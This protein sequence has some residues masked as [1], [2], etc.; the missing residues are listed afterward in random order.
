MTR[1]NP[2][3]QG[4]TH[5]K[6][7]LFQ[8]AATVEGRRIFA[9]GK[10]EREALAR[11]KTARDRAIKAGGVASGERF[12]Q[13]VALWLD[14]LQVRDKT[15]QNYT[16]ECAILTHLFGKTTRL[17]AITPARI[18][19]ALGA[20]R[21]RPRT[22]QLLYLRLKQLFATAVRLGWLPADPMLRVSRPK[23]HYHRQDVWTADQTAAFLAGAGR[24]RS[25]W[26]LLIGAGIRI[27]EARA[28]QWRDLD[29]DA[30]MVR[31]ERTA[32][33]VNKQE[34]IGEPKTRAGIRAVTIPPCRRRAYRASRRATARSGAPWRGQPGWVALAHR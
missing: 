23:H 12:G 28:L 13:L 7:G 21:D 4:V 2:A 18:E 6:D 19:A 3:S 1:T 27:G 29:L 25:L 34:T 32:Q 17:K 16:A 8:A 20:Y 11:L 9:Y 31:I 30:G 33:R 22:R 15:V 5:R 14:R 24:W 10:S 26:L